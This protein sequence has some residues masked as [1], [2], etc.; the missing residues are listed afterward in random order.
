M[1]RVFIA[2]GVLFVF[3][4]TKTENPTTTQPPVTVQEE[5]IKFTTNLDTGTYNVADTLPLVISV[6]SKL[7]TSGLLYS[8]TA[9]WTDSSKQ[10]YK[11]DTSLT[12]S[13]LTLNIPGLKKTGNYALSIAVTSKSTSTNTSSKSIT[14]VNNPLGRF[15]GYKVAPNARQLGTDYWLRGTGVMADLIIQTFQNPLPNSNSYAYQHNFINTGWTSSTCGDFNNDGFVDVFTPGGG[16]YIGFSFLLY[17]PLT[18]T[19]KDTS[20]L[21]DKSIKRLDNSNNS[22]KKTIPVYLNNDNYVDLVIIE[23]DNFSNPTKL[24]ISDG[25]GGYDLILF[26]ALHFV[27]TASVMTDGG[28]IGDLNGDGFPDLVMA[29]NNFTFIYWGKSTAPFFRIDNYTV[30]A[31][32]I[33]NFPNVVN[34]G[35]ICP[36]CSNNVFD[37]VIKDV[38]KDNKPDILLCVVEA[39][40]VYQRLILNKGAGTF[41]NSDVINFPFYGKNIQVHDYWQDESTGD[42]I[43][44]NGGGIDNIFSYWNIYKYKNS[45]GNYILDTTS[46]KFNFKTKQYDGNKGRLLYFDFNKDGIK[47]IGYIDASWGGNNGNFDPVTRRGNIMPFK[48]VFIKRGDQYIEEDFYQYDPYAKS[49]LSILNAR[50][51]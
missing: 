13:I 5:S 25:I 51:K 33:N 15:L 47:D 17:N 28:D 37:I 14:V 39:I 1:K 3:S 20:L 4:C 41:S 36:S 24:L 23:G 26:D 46:I 42:I 35:T 38:N 32:D 21:K 48:T 16:Q 31:S 18:K 30:L 19:F 45:N 8:I 49:L 6:S 9:T 29:A 10:I 11:L 44:Q 34:N 12:Q 7:P 2:L 43:A 27:N 22:P 50:F 40:T